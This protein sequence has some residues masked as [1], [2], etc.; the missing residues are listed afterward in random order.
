M[1]L[2]CRLTTAKGWLEKQVDRVDT[3]SGGVAFTLD[4]R[5]QTT[6]PITPYDAAVHGYTF[7]TAQPVL[8][9][10][11]RHP[12]DA[13]WSYDFLAAQRVTS[14]TLHTSA[15]GLKTLALA[16]DQGTI[17]PSKPFLAF[18]STPTSNSSLVIG[19]KEAFQKAPVYTWL[20]GSLMATPVANGTAPTVSYEYLDGGGWHSLSGVQVSPCVLPVQRVRPAA[21]H[22]PRPHAERAASRRRAGAASSG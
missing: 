2:T 9:V 14:L 19:S 15:W 6:R 17:D 5:R 20:V 12:D 4:P 22:H 10:T 21:A 7:D 11:L 16:N 18:G 1:S 8:L 3:G 13:P